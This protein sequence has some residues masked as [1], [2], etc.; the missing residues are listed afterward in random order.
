MTPELRFLLCAC[1]VGDAP[2][3]P[4]A[5]LDI[6]RLVR[7]AWLH[8]V[9]PLVHAHRE[10]L[11][12]PAEARGLFRKATMATLHRNLQLAAEL[13]IALRAL[14]A[15]DIPVI[16]LKGAHL[17]DA[18]YGNPALR[19]MSDIDLL[20]R[21][22][23]APGAVG[24]LAEAG[25]HADARE[26]AHSN[27][28]DRDIRLA[29]AGVHAL[30]IEVH[31]DLNRSTRHHW[32]PMDDLWARSLPYALD[33]EAARALSP[34]DNAVFL[35]AHAVPHVFAQLIWLRDI[36]GLLTQG[37]DGEALMRAARAARAVRAVRPES[38]WRMR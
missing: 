31:S 3:T 22:E 35:C 34:E 37:L 2:A 9:S 1:S 18:V 4:D 27:R 33:G 6:D 29:K 36:A 23:D 28:M 7:L 21:P 25:Y 13:K 15:A 38:G 16:L 26:A 32:F 5:P 24:A 11:G 12:L 19:P 14:T 8:R 17:M 30:V 10:R 20:I